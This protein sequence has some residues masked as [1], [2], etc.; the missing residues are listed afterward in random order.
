MNQQRVT[1]LA[2]FL[3]PAVL[4]AVL[5]AFPRQE[6]PALLFLCGAGMKAPVTE[7]VREF[8]AQSGIRVQTQFDGSCILRDYIL[9]FRSGDIFLP[10]DADNL[11]QLEERGLISENAFLAWH[12]VA[13]LLS[14]SMK[15]TITSLDD[16]AR[17]GIRIAMSNPRLAS[18]GK[19]VMRRIIDRHPEGRAI[20]DNVKAYGSSSQEIL[21]LYRRGGINAIIEWD[22]LAH[23]PEGRD[24][25]EVPITGPYQVIDPL[26]AG[27]LATSRNPEA[28]RRFYRFL[29]DRGRQ[30]FQKHGYDI[31][32]ALN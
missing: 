28:A 8:E 25:V 27:L 7:I 16:L 15:G 29:L 30:I 4:L 14:P 26:R 20:L 2:C 18:L 22:V 32:E 23:T 1:I 17:P 19:L 12:R 5:L 10:G 6:Q 9:T 3:V 24:L 21:R 11:R 31:D 13:I